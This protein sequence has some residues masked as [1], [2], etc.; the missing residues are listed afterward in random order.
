[1]SLA[2]SGVGG[3]GITS[4]ELAKAIKEELRD[5]LVGVL[6]DT[7]ESLLIS[8]DFELLGL[9]L[10]KRLL[11][12]LH[13]VHLGLLDLH[14]V[15]ESLDRVFNLAGSLSGLFVSNAGVFLELVLFLIVSFMRFD[16]SRDIVGASDLVAFNVIV[17][18]FGEAIFD[19]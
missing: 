13:V 17:S 6:D 16:K 18:I 10:I 8:A 14:F 2:A 11:D 4:H 5:D 1:M 15:F 7:A 12:L 9:S 3:I 19:R